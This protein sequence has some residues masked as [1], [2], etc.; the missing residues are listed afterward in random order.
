[1]TLMRVTAV[2]YTTARDAAEPVVKLCGRDQ[3]G[4]RRVHW[5]RGTRPYLYVQEGEEL[6]IDHAHRVVRFEEGFAATDPRPEYHQT[7]LKRWVCRVPDDVTAIKNDMEETWE[8]D[9]PYYRRCSIDYDLSGYV[10]VPDEK[11]F[12]ID[13]VDTSPEV[14]PE[15]A[16]EPRIVYGDIEV[17]MSDDPIDVML[18]EAD[19][20]I[21]NITLY[22]THEDQYDL[23]VLHPDGDFDTEELTEQ[24]K[25]NGLDPDETE[26][27]VHKTPTEEALL[28]SFLGY[29]E[30]RRPDLTTG[31]NWVNFDVLYL[32]RRLKRLHSKDNNLDINRLSDAGGTKKNFSDYHG[33]LARAVIGVPAVDMLKLF[34]ERIEFTQWRSWSLEYVSQEVLGRGKIADVNV[35]YGFE[36]DRERLAAYNAIDVQLCVEIDETRD[37]IETCMGLAEESQVQIYDV[38]SEMRLVDGYIMARAADDEIL[39]EQ[40]ETDVP[41]NAGGLVLEPARGITEWVGVMDLKSLYPSSIITWNISP[42]TVEWRDN[43]DWREAASDYD[44]KVPWV[45]EASEV[46]YPVTDD[47]I[48]WDRLVTS[49]DEEGLV[50]KYLKLLFKNRAEAK[51]EMAKYENGSTEYETWDRKQYGLKVLM[52]SFYGVSSNDYWRL[53]KH[54]LGDAITSASRYALYKGKELVERQ[55]Y[56][57]IYGDTDSCFFSL[58]RPGGP[59][60]EERYKEKAVLDGKGLVSSVNAGMEEAIRES[61]LD[62]DHPYLDGTLDHET[63]SHCLYYEFEKLY[64]RY[65]QFGKKKRY[66]GLVV[67]KDGKDVDL[68][69]VTGFEAKRS[70]SPELAAEAQREV[71]H[72]VLDGEDFEAVS[73]YVSG[74]CD[75]I[76]KEA[77]DL[78]RIARPKSLGKPMEDYATVTQTVKACRASEQQL[79]KTW[80]KGDDPFLVFL[81]ETPP[82][83][84]AVSVMA[85]E[86]GEDLPDGYS[87]DAEEHIR[88]C[89]E[90]PLEPILAELGWEWRE[91]KNAVQTGDALDGDW[92]DPNVQV[93]GT[94]PD[95]ALHGN[96]QK[97]A[98]GRGGA[99]S[100]VDEGKADEPDDDSSGNALE[101]DW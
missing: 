54:G 37:I 9:I 83:E 43:L 16:I 51:A 25:L 62:G 15:D 90:S 68:L 69:D 81:K 27:V 45:P 89:L 71:L 72:M 47:Q 40:S 32:L 1:M 6:P 31:W 5:I 61:G 33:D 97:T 70:D 20:T 29:F 93:S 24:L 22:D 56:E 79:G 67:W 4:E 65:I 17:L 35:N 52:N 99:S 95:E 30:D 80:M 39:P 21:T 87:I 19:Q 26:V 58:E 77:V 34:R 7:P 59:D 41:E 8:S 98:G 82:L 92:G 76:Q 75:D 14:T 57:V 64:R 23:Y 74:L 86:W 66:A 49:L 10:E 60:D 101:A 46:T 11:E 88:I 91:V 48:E 78:A 73:G 94:E 36:H 63:D 13:D 3:H 96:S 84:P 100:R 50:P 12:H 42:E 2:D 38:F 53:A 55:G 44:L 18:E 28:D 85:L